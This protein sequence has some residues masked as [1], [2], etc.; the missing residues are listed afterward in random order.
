MQNITVI[1][2]GKSGFSTLNYLLKHYKNSNIS[3]I[4]TRPTPPNLEFVPASVNLHT[5]SMNHEILDSSDIIITSPGIDIRQLSKKY[6]NIIGD[7][8]F[9]AQE[10]LKK[11]KYP[12]IIAI[13][14]SNGKSTVT[15]LCTEILQKA[16]IKVSLG[17]NIGTPVLDVIDDNYDAYVLELSSYQLE[18]LKSLKTVS[19]V[20]L[21]L[22]PD[23]LDRYDDMDKYNEAKHN[24]FY[25]TDLAV[26]NQQDEKTYPKNN[27]NKVAFST[28]NA[29]Y[30]IKVE[31]GISTLYHKD[32]ALLNENEIGLV[33][34]H[35]L[36]NIL[37]TYALISPFNLN[38]EQ[39][40]QAIANFKGLPHRTE[41][42]Y[43]NNGVKWVNDSKATNLGSLVAC[44]DGLKVQNTLHL[45]VGGDSKGAD[46][47]E[48]KP[49]LSK[50]K[51][52]LY[53]YGR[54][55]EK[56]LILDDAAL[57]FE[58]ME[59]SIKA[60][61]PTIE[62]G[63]MVLLSPACASLDQFKNFE[64]RGDEFTRLAKIYG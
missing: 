50:F 38:D 3:V 42:I 21:N 23:H 58:T 55:K 39:V 62:K 46:F 5:G 61:A 52:K 60:L 48:L 35:N 54:D 57:S 32:E 59:D 51:L 28:D 31:N 9:F 24:I 34:Q 64:V 53:C 19:A 44:L 18:T 40:K 4:D 36:L 30:F 27:I 2:L 22:S 11:D 56:L 63:D 29:E 49:L 43:E 8:E 47:S 20:H 37:A 10:L 1:G 16:G 26:Y 41:L 13:T 15:T 25:N 12:K 7:V 33:G 45:L 6:T 17:G 14:G